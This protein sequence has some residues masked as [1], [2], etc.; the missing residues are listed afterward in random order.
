MASLQL[1]PNVNV[2]AAEAAIFWTTC[3]VTKKLMLDP[4]LKLRSM[5]QAQTTGSQEYA[6][7]ILAENDQAI[8]TIASKLSDSQNFISG[9]KKDIKS[10]A[11][12]KRDEIVSAAEKD[13]RDTI[14]KMRDEVEK[15]LKEER[16]KLP[17]VISS[18]TD[19][20]YSASIS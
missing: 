15:Q 18:L 16:A 9:M 7:R 19:S 11:Q 13:A 20:V 2:I 12:A 14:T 5:R 6:T 8:D 17:N 3:V 4:Y 1:M 10:V